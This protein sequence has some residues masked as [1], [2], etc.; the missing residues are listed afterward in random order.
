MVDDLSVYILA[1]GMIVRVYTAF[2]SRSARYEPEL[3]PD[4]AFQH[5]SKRFDY[6]DSRGRGGGGDG[7][8]HLVAS[9]PVIIAPHLPTPITLFDYPLLSL[10]YKVISIHDQIFMSKP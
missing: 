10:E 7:A 8:S 2:Y 6:Q 9:V 5:N 1:W 4:K 3:S